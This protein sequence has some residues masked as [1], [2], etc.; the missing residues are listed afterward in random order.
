[1]P[2][3]GGG[4]PSQN[5]LFVLAKGNEQLISIAVEGK[6]SEPF[7]PLV[8]DWFRNPSEGKKKRLAFLC[9]TLGLEQ[10]KVLSIRYQLLHLTA[11][12]LI[13]AER[14]N[15]KHALMMVHSFSPTNEGYE[16]FE[17]FAGLYGVQTERDK[18]ISLGW[19]NGIGLYI[20]WVKGDAAL[21]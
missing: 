8:S 20:G 12:A 18:I 15:A 1:M 19:T 11:S 9:K 7:G 10:D 13:E 14:F 4:N 2:L 6:V 17:K 16:D 3:P 5:D 21:R